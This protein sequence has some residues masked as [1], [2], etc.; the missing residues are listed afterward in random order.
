MNLYSILRLRPFAFFLMFALTLMDATRSIS[1]ESLTFDFEDI[2]TRIQSFAKVESSQQ[3][4]DDHEP[5]TALPHL[6]VSIRP[7][8]QHLIERTDRKQVSIVHP[9]WGGLLGGTVGFFGGGFL[10]AVTAPD[11]VDCGFGPLASFFLGA[12]IGEAFVM[13]LG[14]HYSNKRQGNFGLDLLT[15][16]AVAGGG[17]LML[18]RLNADESWLVLVSVLQIGATVAVER[19]TSQNR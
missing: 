13:P 4:R 17:L 16:L 6:E 14:V 19:V 1:Q 15:S 18:D 3:P 5:L 10:G 2:E 8:R 9:I 11:C 12:T 7:F